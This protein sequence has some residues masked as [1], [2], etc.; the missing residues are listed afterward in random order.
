MCGDKQL[1]FSS[2]SKFSL[3]PLPSTA[4][5][6]PGSDQCNPADLVFD[7]TSVTS[8]VV[9]DF[10]LVCHRSYLTSLLSSLYMLGALFGSY[11]FGWISDKSGRMNSLMI[12]CLSCA[13][14]GS[15]G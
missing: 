9:E 1:Y 11:L 5:F 10:F 2:N 3:F 12:A 14:A 7:H 6:C 4:V 8:S 15:F 13:I